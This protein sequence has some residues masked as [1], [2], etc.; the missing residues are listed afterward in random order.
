M[1]FHVHIWQMLPQLRCGDTCEIWMWFEESNMYFCKIKN[2]PNGE[3]NKLIFSNPIPGWH[4]GST[5]NA[6]MVREL[7][8]VYDWHNM[9]VK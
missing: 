8:W 5:W 2:F 4:M 3:I 6:M 7:I 9:S 1:E